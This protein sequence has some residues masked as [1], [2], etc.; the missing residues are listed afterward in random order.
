MTEQYT[1]GIRKEG[2]GSQRYNNIARIKIYNYNRFLI[3]I[4]YKCHLSFVTFLQIDNDFIASYQASYGIASD[5]TTPAAA[6]SGGVSTDLLTA[7]TSTA[8]ASKASKKREGEKET[9]V[10]VCMA[11]LSLLRLGSHYWS[12]YL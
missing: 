1:N 4:V 12:T 8:T 5:D 2:G 7:T 3:T 9:E 6:G 10:R 11:H